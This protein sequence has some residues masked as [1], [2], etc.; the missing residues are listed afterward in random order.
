MELLELNV[1][2]LEDRDARTPPCCRMMG[3]SSAKCR[4][5]QRIYH[6]TLRFFTIST[7]IFVASYEVEAPN[8]LSRGTRAR[9]EELNR[10][11]LVN[12]LLYLDFPE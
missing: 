7:A 1:G 5:R 4:L 3:N 10:V 12:A 11:Q 8:I 6:T 2:D 9:C